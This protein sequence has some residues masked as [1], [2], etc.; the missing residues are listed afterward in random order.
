MSPDSTVSQRGLAQSLGQRWQIEL[1]QRTT[2]G[3]PH[4]LAD[5][6]GPTFKEIAPSFWTVNASTLLRRF[7]RVLARVSYNDATGAIHGW[8]RPRRSVDRIAGQ[9]WDCL[10]APNAR[11]LRYSGAAGTG[12]VH[13]GGDKVAQYKRGCGGQDDVFQHDKP[14]SRLSL[15]EKQQSMPIVQSGSHEVGGTSHM[16]GG[17]LL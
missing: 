8:H 9:Q 17:S 15:P 6:N 4:D 11:L 13:K 1:E 10:R 12:L 5:A 14:S 7:S 16:A 3:L 2:G